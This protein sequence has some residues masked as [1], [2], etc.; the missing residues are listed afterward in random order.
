MKRDSSANKN[1][2]AYLRME[3]AGIIEVALNDNRALE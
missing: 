1:S 2:S 3:G